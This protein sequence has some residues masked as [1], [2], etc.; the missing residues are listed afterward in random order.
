MQVHQRV[1]TGEKPYKCEACSKSYAQKVGLKI[2]QEQCQIHLNRRGS[3]MTIGTN[4]SESSPSVAEDDGHLEGGM[5][6]VSDDDKQQHNDSLTSFLNG[7]L[8]QR[9]QASLSSPSQTSSVFSSP[10]HSHRSSF[11]ENFSVMNG[12]CP[13]QSSFFDLQPSR[14]LQSH[15]GESFGQSNLLKLSSSQHHH[16]PFGPQGCNNSGGTRGQASFM[17]DSPNTLLQSP[18]S[19]LQ[20][21]S[22]T[23]DLAALAAAIS[24]PPTTPTTPLQPNAGVVVSLAALAAA[25]ANTNNQSLATAIGALKA[26]MELSSSVSSS[27]NPS[28]GQ[29]DRPQPVYATHTQ[30]PAFQLLNSQIH[31]QLLNQLLFQSAPQHQLINFNNTALFQTNTTPIGD[32]VGSAVRTAQQQQLAAA[33]ALHDFSKQQTSATVHTV[34]QH[35]QSSH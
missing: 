25:G 23:P 2:H 19:F 29:L 14:P 16:H 26:L 3:V 17:V 6:M 15:L 22:S 32:V 10:L 24:A 35:P 5:M 28:M 7:A 8:K 21:H 31:Q 33:A 1:H 4:E 30:Q 20:Q 34:D 13:A 9:Q 18:T 27:G 12:G 11:S